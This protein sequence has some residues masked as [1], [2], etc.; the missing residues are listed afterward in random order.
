MRTPL[1]ESTEISLASLR[2]NLLEKVTPL[3]LTYNEAANI[4]RTLQKL[5]WAMRIVVVDSF[6]SDDTLS[7]IAN[8]P[9]VEV[10][11]RKFDTHTTQWNYGLS[12]VQSD[13]VLSLDADYVLTDGLIEELSCLSPPDDVDGYFAAFQYCVSGRPLRGTIL[14]PRQMLFRRSHAIYIDDGHT[15]LLSVERK[16]AMLKETVLHDDRK[17][18]SRWLWAQDRYMIIEAKKLLETPNSALST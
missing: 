15:Q 1:S 13:W 7:I 4:E 17:P 5:S 12:Q 6:S 11:Q 9:Q 18:L 2:L 10:F 14:P 3:I 16:S 8:Y